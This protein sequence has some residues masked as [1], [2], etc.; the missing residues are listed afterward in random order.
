MSYYRKIIFAV[1]IKLHKTTNE[2]HFVV[3][4]R[5]FYFKIIKVSG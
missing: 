3:C 5:L 2:Q 1:K 4:L